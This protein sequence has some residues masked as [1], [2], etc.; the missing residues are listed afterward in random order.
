MY[1]FRKPGNL[2]PDRDSALGP[3]LAPALRKEV[4]IE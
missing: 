1:R 3:A 2:P 4:I